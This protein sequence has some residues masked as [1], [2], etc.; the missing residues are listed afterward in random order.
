MRSHKSWFVPR[1]SVAFALAVAVLSGPSLARGIPIIPPDHVLSGPAR[2]IDGDTIDIAGNRIRLEGIDAPEAGQ[3]CQNARAETWDCGN[4]ATRLLVAMTEHRNVDCKV[5][6]LD[7]Y[8]R[9]LAVCSV[10]GVD[11]N[12]EMVKRGYA[13]AFVKYSKLYVAEEDVAHQAGLGICRGLRCR[14]GTIARANGRRSLPRPRRDARSRATYRARGLSITC[15][16]A[17]GIRRLPC[18]R[19]AGR[20]G[21]ARRP[22]PPLRAG[23]RR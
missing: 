20:G 16:G 4:A 18:R 5:T 17:L 19:I 14:L 10:G 8:G 6:G 12:A 15:R 3:T 22:R 7:K 11:I 23:V 1:G 9:V 13:W 21:S 2:V